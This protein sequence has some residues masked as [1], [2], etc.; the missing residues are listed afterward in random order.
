MNFINRLVETVYTKSSP[1]DEYVFVLP[2]RRAAVFL[3]RAIKK[4]FQDCAFIM[5]KIYAI[6]SFMDELSQLERIDKLDLLFEL[7]TIYLKHIDKSAVESFDSFMSWASILLQD[8]NDIDA[9][10]V[11]IAAVFSHIEDIKRIEAWQV[12]GEDTSLVKRYKQFWL[13]MR[14]YY[15]ELQERLL[16][17]NKAYQG[18]QYREAI[19]NLEFYK[20]NGKLIFAGFNALT[21]AEEL[22]IQHFLTNGAKIYWDIDKRIFEDSNQEGAYFIRKYAQNWNYYK[23]NSFEWI[24]DNFSKKNKV[25]IN[26]IGVSKQVGQGNY[27]N[28]IV[29]NSQNLDTAI[30]LNDENLLNPILNTFHAVD[31]LNVTMGFPIKYSTYANLYDTLF[32]LY[33]NALKY[34]TNQ[35]SIRF[36]YKDFIQFIANPL[37]QK[38][39]SQEGVNVIIHKI[40]KYNWVFL[41]PKQVVNL[42]KNTTLLHFL[43]DLSAMNPTDIL[44]KAI[45]L[46]ELL[47]KDDTHLDNEYLFHFYKL[48]N[49]LQDYNKRYGFITTLKSLYV[50]YHQLIALDTIDLQ[51]E[52]LQGL[53]LMGMLESRMLDFDQV[54]LTSVNEGILPSGQSNNSFIPFEVRLTNELPTYQERDAIFSYHFFRLLYRAKKVH[55][56]YNTSNDTFS[57]GEQSRF[58]LQLKNEWQDVFDIQESIL[59]TDLI[60]S[61]SS[62]LMIKKTPKIIAILKAMAL[63]GF[64]PSALNSF[65]RN[66][67]DFYYKKVLKIREEDEVNEEVAANTFGTIVHNV[68]EELYTPYIDAQLSVAIMDAMLPKIEA[69]VI[70]YFIL[71]YKNEDFKFG[72]NK[73]A[74][75]VAKKYIR[76]FIQKERVLI[77]AGHRIIIRHLETAF[78][79]PLET[80]FDFP[81]NIKG[82]IDRID[83]FDEMPRIID[84]KTGV[85][86]TTDLGISSWD[87]LINGKKE[88]AF[89]VLTYAF[90]VKNG[91]QLFYNENRKIIRKCA[92]TVNIPFQVGV[93]SFKNQANGFLPFYYKPSK[94]IKIDVVDAA[95]IN[96]YQEQLIQVLNELFDSNIPFENKEML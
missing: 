39:I 70:K 79:A 80:T 87:G 75:E 42:F 90:L 1:V 96:D 78:L 77:K 36:Y 14:M 73:I 44:N 60:A 54:I 30:I 93:W 5:P 50:F 59:N 9:Y 68:L 20:P 63:V 19:S 41:S 67:L 65:L 16:S 3:K 28:T 83:E 92:S 7:Y 8:F 62:N 61:E 4:K 88:K 45:K 11:D 66:P 40:N 58:V 69:A 49:K 89:Q 38:L 32:K 46:N 52:P 21:K 13:K 85:V 64:S 74:F 35:K 6:D 22:V 29:S 31:Y 91:K 18:L 43:F 34:S 37:I 23:N 72:K 95:I 76:D 84:Y 94:S 81:I 56:L 48:F 57:Y 47:K 86:S 55:L 17:E 12:D 10:L 25:K 26:I 27:V 33:E 82:V 51:G 53:Q 15:K 2:S 71:E 24:S